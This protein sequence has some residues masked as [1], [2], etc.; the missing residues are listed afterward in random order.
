MRVLN[1]TDVERIERVLGRPLTP[2]ELKEALTIDALSTSARH[3]A[4]AI[5]T[6][7]TQLAV[8]YLR[9]VAPTARVSTLA[10]FLE[11][12]MAANGAS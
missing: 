11:D 5:A 7:S 12:L 1:Q 10:A 3:T 4:R 2:D 8:K 9:E 6:Q